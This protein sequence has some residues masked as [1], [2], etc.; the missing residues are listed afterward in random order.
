MRKDN[1]SGLA[2]GATI[3]LLFASSLFISSIIIS[4]FALQ[5]YGAQLAGNNYMSIP[6]FTGGLTTNASGI[7]V[8][9]TG[10]WAHD[11]NT[12]YYTLAIPALLASASSVYEMY[13]LPD[14]QN[15][16]TNTYV[17]NNT[18]K[19]NYEIVLDEDYSGS[20]RYNVLEIKEDGFHIRGPYSLIDPSTWNNDILFI[21]YPNVNQVQNV[22]ITTIYN[23]K[24]RTLQFNFNGHDYS[25]QTINTVT[26]NSIFA[27]IYGG[28]GAFDVGFRLESFSTLNEIGNSQY[29]PTAI[30]SLAQTLAFISIMFKVLTFKLPDY[31][32]PQLLQWLLISTQEFGLAVGIFAFIR[33]T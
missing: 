18:P 32:M 13:I 14:S 6:E 8:T 17:I 2:T 7:I 3:I 11:T 21:S 12:G 9:T 1:E 30:D 23:T 28:V 15:I 5:I 10:T 26:D 16:I 22:I 31:V 20:Y 33:G 29:T 19:T 24:D 4:Y 27:H 25:K